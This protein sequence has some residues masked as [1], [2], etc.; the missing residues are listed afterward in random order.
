MEG[1]DSRVSPPDVSYLLVSPILP[2]ISVFLTMSFFTSHKRLT[3]VVD[4]TSITGLEPE[5][6]LTGQQT[7]AIYGDGDFFTPIRRLRDW[8]KKLSQK[9][10]S[11]FTFSE[12]PGAGHF[13]REDDTA[14]QM[15]RAIR[16]CIGNL[17]R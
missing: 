16:T 1:E 5:E 3:T 10:D 15:G 13:W 9:P 11:Q 4:G 7:V 12:I 14:S 6:A 17:R 8:S 2:P